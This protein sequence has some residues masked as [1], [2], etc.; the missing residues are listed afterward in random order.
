[1]R[2]LASAARSKR[3]HVPAIRI[4]RLYAHAE[5]KDK[6]YAGPKKPATPAKLP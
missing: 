5:D 3:A 2:T 6:F 4:A 1:M